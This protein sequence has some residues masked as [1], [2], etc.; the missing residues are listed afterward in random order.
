MYTLLNYL[1]VL[2]IRDTRGRADASRSL[3]LDV[4]LPAVSPDWCAAAPPGAVG[5]EANADGQ[6]AARTV[7]LGPIMSPNAL[8]EQARGR[9]WC[10]YG[11]LSL[12]SAGLSC[13]A[14]PRSTPLATAEVDFFVISFTII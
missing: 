13:V 11:P 6:L 7:D 10:C 12:V 5:W 4:H 9:A 8:A 14:L 1:Q 2:C 3:L